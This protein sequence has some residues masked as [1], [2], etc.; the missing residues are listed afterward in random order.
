[1]DLLPRQPHEPGP[2]PNFAGS[3]AEPA[4]TR[5][6]HAG[7]LSRLGGV[8]HCALLATPEASPTRSSPPH[9]PGASPPVR[10][11]A[12]CFD[13]LG[14]GVPAHALGLG[15][16]ADRVEAVA[17]L[18]DLSRLLVDLEISPRLAPTHI[19]VLAGQGLCVRVSDLLGDPCP[20]GLLPTAPY[21]APEILLGDPILEL[22]LRDEAVTYTLGALLYHCLTGSPPYPGRAAA[23]VAERVL[24]SGGE[25]PDRWPL[26]VQ[27][28]T[29][30]IVAHCLHPD[31]RARP[32]SLGVLTRALEEAGRRQREVGR[33]LP[34]TNLRGLRLG[35]GRGLLVGGVLLA[36][37]LAVLEARARALRARDL[38]I[39]LDGVLELRPFPVHGEDPPFHV[40]AVFLLDSTALDVRGSYREAPVYWAQGWAHLRAQQTE[41]ALDCLRRGLRLAPDSI[42]GRAS[43]GIVLIEHGDV[44]GLAT[45]ERV[46]ALSARSPEDWLFQ[47][48]A[49]FYLGRFAVAAEAF[50]VAAE[51]GAGPVARLHWALATL[52]A[53]DLATCRVALE[54][55]RSERPRDPWAQWAQ[56]ELLAAE[57]RT[58]AALAVVHGHRAAL[59]ADPAILLRVALLLE[60]LGEAEASRAWF[61]ELRSTRPGARLGPCL[62]AV[63]ALP[64]GRFRCPAR[65]LLVGVPLPT[66]PDEATSVEATSDPPSVLEPAPAWASEPLPEPAPA[67]G[68]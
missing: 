44:G 33:R 42:A 34:R 13:A 52:H 66:T 57:G 15:S 25:P 37:G 35:L 46:L 23:E 39:Q 61:A 47:G 27:R 16:V 38:G 36:A 9:T 12:E 68:G 1:M 17:R 43:L 19:Q 11:L 22:P 59:T 31:P 51:A 41:L 28:E 58:E 24:Q 20:G 32:A 45:L 3:G 48:A 55:A 54:Q 50:R 67:Q 30:E 2:E 62:P 10:S 60:R 64:R 14:T 5:R 63:I 6:R 49:A 40:G 29:R 26:D 18:A 65:E 53:G 21:L 7:R 8:R 56:A 4:R